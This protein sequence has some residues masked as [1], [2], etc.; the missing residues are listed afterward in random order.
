MSLRHALHGV[1]T[2]IWWKIA[3]PKVRLLTVCMMQYSTKLKQSISE[4]LI[5]RIQAAFLRLFQA[6]RKVIR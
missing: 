1:L 5:V 6:R 2:N 4:Y 3:L